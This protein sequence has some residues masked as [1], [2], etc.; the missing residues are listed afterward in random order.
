MDDAAWER[1]ERRR[2]GIEEAAELLRAGRVTAAVAAHAQALSPHVGEPWLLAVRDPRAFDLDLV[3]FLP[4]LAALSPDWVESAVLDARYSGYVARAERQ[5]A[6]A[7]RSE[8]LRIPEGFDYGS[9]EGLSTESREKLEAI[10]PA[11]L[12]QAARISGVRPSDAA[13]LMVRLGRG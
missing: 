5:A 11:T 6:R 8:T 4:E 10:R 7:G 9:V 3:D 1:F 13:L 2:A 12:G